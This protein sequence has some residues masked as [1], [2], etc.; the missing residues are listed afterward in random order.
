MYSVYTIID[1]LDA[2]PGEARKAPQDFA[3]YVSGTPASEP[4]TVSHVIAR[5]LFSSGAARGAMEPRGPRLRGQ[6]RLQA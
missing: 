6:A 5:P 2:H 4:W 3:G 1:D